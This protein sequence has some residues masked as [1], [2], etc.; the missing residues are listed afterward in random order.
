MRRRII[1]TALSTIL[2]PKRRRTTNTLAVK[3]RNSDLTERWDP[4]HNR[5]GYAPLCGG[6]S[7]RKE[8]R[9]QIA[10]AQSA[11]RQTRRSLAASARAAPDRGHHSCLPPAT[12]RAHWSRA[13]VI[14]VDCRARRND[15]RPP[16]RA[17]TKDCAGGLSMIPVYGLSMGGGSIRLFCRWRF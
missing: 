2:A 14:P 3:Q 10:W 6:P 7:H 4:L 8:A 9:T 13:A 11:R 1:G 15:W 17:T 5:E 16:C 12:P